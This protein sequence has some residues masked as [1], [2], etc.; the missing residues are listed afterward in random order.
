MITSPARRNSS[1]LELRREPRRDA[2]LAHAAQGDAREELI[3]RGRGRPDPVADAP[4]GVSEQL[5]RLD[6]EGLVVGEHL[7]RLE[8]PRDHAWVQDLLELFEPARIREHDVSKLSAID[9]LV[10]A[11]H[12]RAELLHDGAVSVVPRL[13]SSRAIAS[14]SRTRAP[15]SRSIDATVLFPAPIGP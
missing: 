12:P 4:D 3:A 6:D 14:A 15:S 1:S 9:L 11:E 5:D 8:D 2:G 13:C 10:L 7:P